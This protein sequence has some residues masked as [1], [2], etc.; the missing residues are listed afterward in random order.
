MSKGNGNDIDW[1]NIVKKEAIG[2]NGE[3]LGEV[4]EVGKTHIITQKGIINRKR[5][6]LPKKSVASFNGSVLKL[7]M[8]NNDLEEY[9][10]TEGQKFEGYSSFKSSDMTKE[11]ETKIPVMAQHLE[12][13][14][15]LTENK[16]KIIKEPIKEIKKVDIDLT[17]EELIIERIPFKN[18]PLPASSQGN[19]DSTQSKTELVIQLKREEPVIKKHSYVKEEIIIRKKPVTETKTITEVVVNERINYDNNLNNK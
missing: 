18:E 1:D 11:L 4:L 17:H 10:E 2:L 8:T 15:R 9:K 13:S 6:Y 5:Y 16:F 3:D 12:V 7:N 19:D 14:K